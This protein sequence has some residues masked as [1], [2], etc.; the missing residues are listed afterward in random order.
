MTPLL[1]KIGVWYAHADQGLM[2]SYLQLVNKWF[3][4]ASLHTLTMMCNENTDHDDLTR[5]H[6]FYSHWPGGSAV[7][8]F[9]HIAQQ[10]DTQMTSEFDFG[11]LKNM[12]MYESSVPPRLDF[13]KLDDS[14]I[15]VALILAKHDVAV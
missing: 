2:S 10:I 4:P 12:E 3:Y 6:V 8:N 9:N 15:P 5:L 11:P 1:D 14:G 13:D 7:R